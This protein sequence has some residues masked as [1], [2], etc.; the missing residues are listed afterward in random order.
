MHETFVE[1]QQSTRVA[2]QLYSLTVSFVS[3]S[4]YMEMSLPVRLCII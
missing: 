1:V 2:D 4:R 3:Y